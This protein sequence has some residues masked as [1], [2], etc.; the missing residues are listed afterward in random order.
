MCRFAGFT[1]FLHMWHNVKSLI[2][3]YLVFVT[4]LEYSRIGSD[5][6]EVGAP[7]LETYPHA[8]A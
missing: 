5:T 8:S 2:V 3:P 1:T 4:E 7:N 6:V